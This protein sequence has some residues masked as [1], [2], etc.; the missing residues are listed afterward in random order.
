MTDQI[1]LATA[2]VSSFDVVQYCRRQIEDREHSLESDG[3]TQTRKVRLVSEIG[4]FTD[5]IRFIQSR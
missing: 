2:P 1:K 4:A 5:V 3:Q